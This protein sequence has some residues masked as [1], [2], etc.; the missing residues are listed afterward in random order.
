MPKTVAGTVRDQGNN[1]KKRHKK[2]WRMIS[3]NMRTCFLFF[4]YFFFLF[5]CLK[6]VEKTLIRPSDYNQL[7]ETCV[8]PLVSRGFCSKL[9]HAY[10]CH[11]CSALTRACYLR[12]SLSAWPF[13]GETVIQKAIHKSNHWAFTICKGFQKINPLQMLEHCKALYA[14]PLNA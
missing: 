10:N 11:F 5:F 6:R 7:S 2:R 13:P 14:W 9:S 12:L 3:Q 1:V 4:S 8:V